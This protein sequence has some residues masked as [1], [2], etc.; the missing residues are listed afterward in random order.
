MDVGTLDE[1]QTQEYW[2]T[3]YASEEGTTYD[4]FKK[5]EDIKD[6]ILERIPSK[7]SRILELG[8]GNSTITP[9]LHDLGYANV[10]SLDFSPNLISQMRA[11][12]PGI[13]FVEMDI[14]NLVEESDKLQA[15]AGQWDLIIDKGT[16]DA[17][18]AEKGSVWE[19]SERVFDNARREID[20]VLHLLKPGGTFLY[21]TWMQPHFRLRFLER[22][23]D[24]DVTVRTINEG[25]GWDYFLFTGIKKVAP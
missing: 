16:L 9:S 14:R 1:L 8:C 23:A 20:G 19:P 5:F 10:T 21:L 13:D 18:V 6:I 2:D 12:H 7:D 4:W 15:G 25:G 11:R 24:W 17:L 22:K 3:R